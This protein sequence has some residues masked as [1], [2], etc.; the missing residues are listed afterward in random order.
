MHRLKRLLLW[1][2]GI[3]MLSGIAYLQVISP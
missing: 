3:A 1:V 2:F